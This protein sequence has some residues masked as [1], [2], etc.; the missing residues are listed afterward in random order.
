M[1]AKWSRVC[2]VGIGPELV[3]DD[4]APAAYSQSVR[5]LPETLRVAFEVAQTCERE[6]NAV[7]VR[8]YNLNDSS[9]KTAEKDGNLI[10]LKAGYRSDALDATGNIQ[11]SKMPVITLADISHVHSEHAGADWVTTIEAQDGGLAYK[12][13]YVDQTIASPADAKQIFDALEA[14]FAATQT[15]TKRG[16]GKC[17]SWN[18]VINASRRIATNHW[19][20]QW[21]EDAAMKM[22]VWM[23][24]ATLFGWTRDIFESM[25]ER[26]NLVWFFLNNQLT[27]ADLWGDVGNEPLTISPIGEN[28][29][30]GSPARLEH[31]GVSF[32]ALLDGR[33]TPWTM[34]TLADCEQT[35][36]NGPYKIA[37]AHHTGD[38]HG[39]D[40]TT[41]CEAIAKTTS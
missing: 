6:P 7:T 32:S 18:T 36:F 16:Y 12:T 9:R 33:L 29:L 38:T 30:I 20:S 26:H 1:G 40:W 3:N 35:E 13:A 11:P 24:G 27:V 31:G 2:Y 21:W 37:L 5:V 17:S 23:K 25:A 22:Q 19:M 8:I 10:I 34:Q 28:R 15:G 41:A 4:I 14:S 39:N